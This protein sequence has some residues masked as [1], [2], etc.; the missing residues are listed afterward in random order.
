V[1]AAEDTILAR[2][3]EA[4]RNLR[5]QPAPARVGSDAAPGLGAVCPSPGGESDLG[6][7]PGGPGTGSRA[8]AGTLAG[9]SEQSPAAAWSVL[10]LRFCGV[11]FWR[12]GKAAQVR[13]DAETERW[14]SWRPWRGLRIATGRAPNTRRSLGVLLGH[15]TCPV[16]C[17]HMTDR[18][19]PFA[20]LAHAVSCSSSALASFRS[21]VSKPSVNQPYTGA[22]RSRASA[23][24]P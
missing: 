15:A 5:V 1:R 6:P 16:R 2:L 3:D 11:R 14:G 23:R 21:S 19:Q 22:S 20:D 18:L 8:V 13:P 7:R 17:R 12:I 24:L 4:Q 10:S 9:H